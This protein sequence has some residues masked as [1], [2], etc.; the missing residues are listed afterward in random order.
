[1]RLFVYSP[2]SD[3]ARLHLQECLPNESRSLSVE[4]SPRKNSRT[5]CKPPDVCCGNRLREWLTAPLPNLKFWQIDLRDLSGI[6]GGQLL[7]S[8]A[9]MG[10]FFA[11]PAPKPWWLACSPS[12]APTRVGSAASR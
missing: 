10:D 8:V 5:P 9:N 11:W 1:M 6:A 3:A 12:T 7:F 4:T 2:L